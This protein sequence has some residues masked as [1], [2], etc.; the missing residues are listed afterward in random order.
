MKISTKGG[1]KGE[2]S[3]M[4]GRRVSKACLRVR[5]YGC[6]DELSASIALARA[7]AKG[8]ELA[9]KLLQIQKKLV[10]LMTELATAKNDFHLLAEKNIKLLDETDLRELEVEIEQFESKGDTFTGWKHA[11]DTLLDASLDVARV[12]CR[13]AEREII[14]LN[15]TEPLPRDFPIVYINRLS[16]LLY[17]YSITE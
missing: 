16:D 9:D 13:S 17:L 5:A 8:S 3:L 14:A 12:K 1:D 15:E 11:G 7:Y 2:T 6:V 10:F 4:F